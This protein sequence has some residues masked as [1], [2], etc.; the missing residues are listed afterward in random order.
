MIPSTNIFTTKIF[1][2]T[3]LVINSFSVSVL[4]RVHISKQ[5]LSWRYTMDKNIPYKKTKDRIIRIKLID[6]SQ[7]NGQVNLNRDPQ[8][9]RLSDLVASEREP[10]LILFNV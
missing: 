10:F 2:F 8:Y 3:S 6:G 7:V 1:K 5:P 9:G 4:V